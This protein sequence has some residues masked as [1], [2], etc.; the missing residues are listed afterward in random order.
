MDVVQF[1]AN[2]WDMLGLILT[3]ILALFIHPPLRSTR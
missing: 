3:N 1:L 2:N